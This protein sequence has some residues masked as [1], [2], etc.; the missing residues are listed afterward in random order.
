MPNRILPVLVMVLTAAAALGAGEKPQSLSPEKLAEIVKGAPKLPVDLEL[1]LTLRLTDF[2]DCTKADDPHDFLDQST[3]KVA[4][5]PAGKYR[6][7]AAH[8]HAFFAYRFRGAGKDKPTL[9]VI[10]YPDD[11]VRNIYFGTHESVLTGQANMDWSLETG[12]YTGDPLP[13]T[14]RMQYHTFFLWPQDEWPCVIVAN[15]MRYGSNGAASRIWVY[16]IEGKLP[17]LDVSPPA[18]ANSRVLGHYNSFSGYLSSRLYFGSGSPQ[19]VEH[20]LDY[21]DYVG[22]NEISGSVVA[23][24]SWGFWCKI[25]SWDGGDKGTHLDEVLQAMDARGGWR[26]VA[27]FSLGAGFKAGGKALGSMGTDELKTA[28]FKGFDEFLDRYG[29]FKSLKG[30]ALGAQYGLDTFD[31][32]KSKGVEKDVVAHLKSKRPDLDVIAYLGG[33]ALH[34]PYFSGGATGN[35]WNVVSHWEKSGKPWPEFLGEQALLQWQAW[36]HDPAEMRKI[37]GL[38]ILEQYQPD[39]HRIF[40]LYAQ[41][42]RALLYYDLDRSQRRS[43]LVATAYANLWNTHYEGWFGLLPGYNF[44]YRKLWVAPDFNAPPPCSLAS[45]TRAVGHRDRLSIVAGSWNVKYFGWEARMRTFAKAFRALPPEPMKD[46]PTG[47]ADTVRVRWLE[48]QG[49]RY[50]SLA[51]LIPFASEATVDGRAVKLPPYELVA[52]VDDGKA[53]PVVQASP[54]AEYRNWVE[55]RIANFE[56]SCAEVKALDA[57]AVSEAYENA[58]KDARKLLQDGKLLAA[59]LALGVGLARELELRRDI[60]SPPAVKAPKIAAAPPLNGDLNAWPKEAA[61]LR[62]E[63]G[64]YLA[65]HL[66]FPNSWQGPKDLSAR[67]RLGHDGEKLYIGVAVADDVLEAGDSC[68]FRLSE[69]SYRAWREEEQ[70]PDKPGWNVELPVG[71]DRTTGTGAGGFRYTCQR[72]ATGYVLEASASLAEL[73]LKPGGSMGFLLFLEDTDGT[74]NLYKA[75]WARKQALLFPHRPTFAYWSDA[76]TCGRL[77]IE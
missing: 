57:E 65:G 62:A 39:D 66:Y 10:E 5:G 75:G 77:I 54:C 59:D 38:T 42:P 8:R 18:P 13:L 58:A 29:K 64:E 71:K 51:S 55:K 28:L 15:W 25:P 67:V 48:Y 22:V 9:V 6:V 21:F 11:A 47:P 56:K 72:T 41:E 3:S 2:M 69:K 44:W 76:R 31:F 32:L 40:D 30:V 36:K 17:K 33:K 70:K 14:N 52:L 20:M 53:A 60:L 63:S 37:P 43:D 12:V 49:K 46:V 23:N 35:T 26:Y 1:G 34:E 4:E 19:A 45:F 74:K 61:D 68:S 16:A 73:G 27:G 7:T 24:N 50:V